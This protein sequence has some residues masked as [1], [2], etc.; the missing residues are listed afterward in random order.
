MHGCWES[1]PGPQ[2]CRA[3]APAASP[4]SKRGCHLVVGAVEE[5]LQL[6]SLSLC[7]EDGALV[8]SVDCAPVAVTGGYLLSQLEY[9]NP[10]FFLYDLLMTF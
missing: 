10:V 9:S 5:R 1:E 3:F 8:V 7:P 4:F 6:P 2:A